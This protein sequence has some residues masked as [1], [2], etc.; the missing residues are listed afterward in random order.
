MR[1]CSD[2]VGTLPDRAPTVR[3]VGVV[4]AEQHE[5]WQV[6]RRYMSTE[7]LEKAMQPSAIAS[8]LEEGV[9][10]LLMAS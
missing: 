3:L 10:P 4:L 5:E 2:V 1:Q 9:V 7:A 8:E 6:T